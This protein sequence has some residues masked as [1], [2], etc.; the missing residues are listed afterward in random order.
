MN[1]C[2]EFVPEAPMG[3]YEYDTVGLSASVCDGCGGSIVAHDDV[4]DADLEAAGLTRD[5][6]EQRRAR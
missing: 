1:G 3:G 6:Y 4:T 5:E 2:A